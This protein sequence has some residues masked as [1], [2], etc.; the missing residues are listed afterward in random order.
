MEPRGTAAKAAKIV[1]IVGVFMLVGAI[2]IEADM[3]RH[4]LNPMGDPEFRFMMR[5]SRPWTLS[6]IAVFLVGCGLMASTVNRRYALI[7]G[8]GLAAFCVVFAATMSQWVN[9][10][11]WT[12]VFLFI[13]LLGCAAALIFVGIS[14]GR[15]VVHIVRRKALSH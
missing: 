7:T 2:A 1:L 15:Y 4:R 11:D 10:H 6:A 9:V 14:L 12:G 13:W 3:G 5:I 8:G